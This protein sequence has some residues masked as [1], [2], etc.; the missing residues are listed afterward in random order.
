MISQKYIKEL[1]FNNIDEF[2]NYVVESK[3]NGNYSQTKEFINKM[4]K[5]QRIDFKNYLNYSETDAETKQE[6]LNIILED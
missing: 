3:I 4:S 1:E 6:L 2:F 5:S